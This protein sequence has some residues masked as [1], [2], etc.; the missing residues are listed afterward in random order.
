[1]LPD[2]CAFLGLRTGRVEGH[3]Y[4]RS[5]DALEVAREIDLI[6]VALRAT[7]QFRHEISPRPF[8]TQNE[9]VSGCPSE[10]L[11]E[12]WPSTLTKS[13][14]RRA[15]LVN[16]KVWVDSIVRVASRRGEHLSMVSPSA[17][18]HT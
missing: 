7:R 18:V 4:G 12:M 2:E 14:N 9:P 17:R 16:H 13:Q 10:R 6:Y 1:M 8:L 5:G 3:L 15:M 11:S